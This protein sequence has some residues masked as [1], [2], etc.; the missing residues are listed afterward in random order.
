MLEYVTDPPPKFCV[1]PVD[2]MYD[3]PVVP[4]PLDSVG[5]LVLAFQVPLNCIALPNAEL[6]T[7]LPLIVIDVPSILTPPNALVVAAGN[8]YVLLPLITPLPLIVIVVP[9][10][11]T[12]PNTLVLAVGKVYAE[13]TVD[14][15]NVLPSVVKYFPLLPV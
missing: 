12:P 7:P 9:S 13:A 5:E 1:P 4:V 6:I 2:T 8:V 11:L 3:Q 10:T 14:Q 15:L